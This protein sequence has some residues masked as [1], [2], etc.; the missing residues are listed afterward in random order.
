MKKIH[1]NPQSKGSLG[2]SFEVE[3]R[4]AFLDGIGV[5]WHG[6][7][8]DDRHHTFLDRHPDKVE[9]V[10]LEDGATDAMLGL[11][12]DALSRPEPVILI[13][14][15]AQAD[16]LIMEAFNSLSIFQRAAQDGAEFI[17]SLFPSDDNE[18]LANLA[19]IAKWG[20]G[21][22]QFL[23]I[24]NPTKS[25]ARIFD[26]S[27]LKGTL[28]E[29]LGARE[30]SI[31]SVTPTTLG[32]LEKEEREARRAISFSE[33]AEGYPGVDALCTG[34][35]AYLLSRMARQYCEVAGMLLPASELEKV[36]KLSAPKPTR[37]KELDFSL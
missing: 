37:A 32:I 10:S 15:R 27:P 31:P 16:A 5:A 33:F 30:L 34:E 7:D 14:C 18:S 36:P 25:K 26:V 1:I 4:A 23:I 8:L 28:I 19:E 11:V 20:Y 22:A 24:R 9:L 3:T 21:Q 12:K 17:I 6:Y 13:D 29:K 2:K 35:I